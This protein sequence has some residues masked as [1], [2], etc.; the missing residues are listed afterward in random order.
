M[1]C[2]NSKLIPKT[3]YLDKCT[4]IFNKCYTTP[5]SKQHKY[6]SMLETL[7]KGKKHFFLVMHSIIRCVVNGDRWSPTSLYELF[8]CLIMGVYLLM[9]CVYPNTLFAA[10]ISYLSIW[11]NGVVRF[12][13]HVDISQTK[14]FHVVL[15]MS[16]ET[17]WWVWDCLKLWCGKL[18][19][20]DSFFSIKI[21]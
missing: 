4:L 21:K 8:K 12:V 9:K 5:M 16:S 1:E 11:S 17:S 13:C 3:P 7:K 20:I 19:I 2:G 6:N 18:L 14:V 10:H 15:L